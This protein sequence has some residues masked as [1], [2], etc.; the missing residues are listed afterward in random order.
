MDRDIALALIGAGQAVL[1][2]LIGVAAVFLSKVNGKVNKVREDSAVTRTQV[3]NDHSTN[4]REEQDERHLEA[5][6]TLG[7]IVDKLDEQGR[8]LDTHGR[9]LDDL[10]SSDTVLHQRAQ[11]N[12]DRIHDLE[13]THPRQ[14]VQEIIRSTNHDRFRNPPPR[15]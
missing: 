5:T 8:K 3:A 4:L 1:V 9:R 13:K 12:S 15:G 6:T 10:F 11:S 2:A 7:T 14:Q